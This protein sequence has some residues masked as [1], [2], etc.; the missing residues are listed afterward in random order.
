LFWDELFECSPLPSGFDWV[1]QC[2]KDRSFRRLFA[3]SIDEKL[4]AIGSGRALPTLLRTVAQH[5]GRPNGIFAWE[6]VQVEALRALLDVPD[7]TGV[8]RSSARCAR[9]SAA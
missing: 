9:I 3:P 6:H 4:E 5:W 1:P 8:R 2:L 7:P